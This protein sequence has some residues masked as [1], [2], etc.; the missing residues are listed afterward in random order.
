MILD[1]RLILDP[2]LIFDPRLRFGALE[3]VGIP[4]LWTVA[5]VSLMSLLEV[6]HLRKSFD[7]K[8]A[9]EDLS[10]QVDA[11][12]VLGLLGPNG[13]GKSTTML[14]VAGLRRPDSGTVTIAGQ[15][16]DD[17]N[18]VRQQTLG[19]VPQD[20]AIYPDLT[21]RENLDFFGG[22][23][24]LRGVELKRRVD[25]TLEQIG[26][27]AHAGEFVQTF[28]GGMKRRLNFGAALLHDPKLVILDEPTVGIDAQSRSHLLDCIRQL[29]ASG[30]GIIYASHYMEEIE[31][32]C[33]R[34][35]ILDHG[36]LLACGPIDELLDETR[37]DVELRVG[38]PADRLGDRLDDLA[39]VEPLEGDQARVVIRRGRD[40]APRSVS[41]RLEKVLSVLREMNAELLSIATKEH[42]LEELFLELTG[43]KLR[44]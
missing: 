3:R 13:S 17:G 31:S 23:Y 37:T 26:L 14:M 28:S 30:V 11:G 34:V 24:G 10:F 29:S 27:A 4:T 7:S 42:N 21:A 12:E 20:L 9:V 43:R 5:A 1:P 25:R 44:D 6:S 19:F 22:I 33:R 36:K 18:R 15:L 2:P 39:T 35:A 8:V 41:D 32:T 38:V 40:D 16:A